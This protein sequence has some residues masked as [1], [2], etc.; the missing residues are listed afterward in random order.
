MAEAEH[1]GF[2]AISAAIESEIAQL[3]DAEQEEFLA[4]LGLPSPASTG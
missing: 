1:A 4:T 3:P 2:V